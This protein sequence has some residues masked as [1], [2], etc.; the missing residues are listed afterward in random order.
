MFLFIFVTSKKIYA[1]V[2]WSIGLL[3]TALVLRELSTV[4]E[5]ILTLKS[6]FAQC[7]I[8]LTCDVHTLL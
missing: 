1:I 8:Y 4:I 5:V 3:Q 7:L 6:L 2:L